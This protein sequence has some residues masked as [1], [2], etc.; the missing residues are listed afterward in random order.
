MISATH[1]DAQTTLPKMDQAWPPQ[2]LP[3]L[4]V[5][6]T[7]HCLTGSNIHTLTDGINQSTYLVSQSPL[8]M[9]PHLQQELHLHL[10]DSFT[11]GKQHSPMNHKSVGVGWRTC[12]DLG[13]VI[14]DV[15][16]VQEFGAPDWWWHWFAAGDNNVIPPVHK[17]Q[18]QRHSFA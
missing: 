3:K 14:D 8:V 12:P 5:Q 11:E 4:Q 16:I 2:D 9:E 1:A 7:K 17:L 15:L 13:C 18:L 10:P 6:P